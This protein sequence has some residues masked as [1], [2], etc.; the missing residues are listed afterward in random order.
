L[1]YMS[2]RH[3]WAPQL[4]ATCHVFAGRDKD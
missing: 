3:S 1:M 2:V 4:T